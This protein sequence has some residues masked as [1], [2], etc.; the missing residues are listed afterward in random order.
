MALKRERLAQRRKTVGHMQESLAEKLGVDRTTVV[1][2]ERAESEPQP[3]VRPWLADALRV[4]PDELSELLAEIRVAEIPSIRPVRGLPAADAPAD[5]SGTTDGPRRQ[6]SRDGHLHFVRSLRMADRRVGGGH[7][8]ATVTAYLAAGIG[9]PM[10]GRAARHTPKPL[11]AAAASLSEMAGW[12]AHDAGAAAPARRHLG[13]ALVLAQRSGDQQ[14]LAQVCAG[15]S[16]LANHRGEASD[17]LSHARNGL[18]HLRQVPPHGRL[19]ARLLA[20]QARGLAIA[21]RP[22]EATSTLADAEAALHGPISSAS[23]WLSPFDTTSLAV[24]AAR[25]LLRI[26]DL[27]EAQRQ[28]QDLL[29]SGPA[30]RVRSRA[31]AQLMLVTV[32]L[33]KGQIDEACA[34]THQTLD[35]IA[36]LGSAVIIDQLQHVSVLLRSRSTASI[37]VPPLLDRLQVTI[38]ERSWMSMVGALR[39]GAVGAGQLDGG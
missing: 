24:E 2:W 39:V 18:K 15:L 32:L 25:C 23:K 28:L 14:L 10:T 34:I 19:Q 22:L 16:H 21:G 17:A 7:L 1:R 3:W 5:P 20:M 33:G 36:S 27:L 31:F 8:Y 9:H 12:M 11:L 30:D 37:D 35:E 38:H 26:G 13:E 4:S 6:G 29:A